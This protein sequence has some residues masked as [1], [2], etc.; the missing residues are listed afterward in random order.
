MILRPDSGIL[1]PVT[2]ETY[3]GRKSASFTI[4]ITRDAKGEEYPLFYWIPGRAS[5]PAWISAAEAADFRKKLKEIDKD[6]ELAWHPI[7]GR[8]QIWYFAPHRV[9]LPYLQGW[10]CL[11]IAHDPREDAPDDGFIPLGP[12]L[13]AEVYAR[14]MQNF[15]GAEKYY[16]EAREQFE[17]ERRDAEEH[18]SDPIV[19]HMSEWFDYTKI[20][21]IGQGNKSVR[22]DSGD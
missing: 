9:S 21:N 15:G 20:K 12:K 2:G 4:P 22:F 19:E 6:L 3:T 18:A 16:R 17:R 7:L 8:W 13:L 14:D 11:T 1:N 5:D 10:L